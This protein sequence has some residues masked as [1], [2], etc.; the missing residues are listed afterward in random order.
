MTESEVPWIKVQRTSWPASS[1]RSRLTTSVN[2]RAGMLDHPARWDFVR[3][4]AVRNATAYFDIITFMTTSPVNK[5]R[6]GLAYAALIVGAIATLLL[7]GAV[8]I[9]LVTEGQGLTVGL[10]VSLFYYASPVIGA[11]AIVIG[12]IGVIISRVKAISIIGV[13]L[14]AVPIIVVVLQLITG[15]QIPLA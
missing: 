6:R 14:G 3:S 10:L 15:Y 9:G 1:S 13:V 12:T 5:P 8:L 2:D 4:P 7:A 11:G